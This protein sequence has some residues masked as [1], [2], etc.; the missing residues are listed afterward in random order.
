LSIPILISGLTQWLADPAHLILAFLAQAVVMVF[1]TPLAVYY[2]GYRTQHKETTMPNGVGG[3][4]G[5]GTVFGNNATIVGGRGGDGGSSGI[6]GQGGGGYAQGDNVTIFG[7]DGGNAATPDGR[8]GRG[9][10]SSVEKTD[11]PTELW[12]FGC[13]GSSANH[14]EYDRRIRQ[15]ARVRKDYT[16]LLPHETPFIDAGVDAIPLLYVNKRLQELGETWQVSLGENGTYVLP[17]LPA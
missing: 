16:H 11:W 6:G 12:K 14:P 10:R 15:L 7:G 9:A 8:G 13:A 4:G 3:A 17:P 5:S 2:I 1:L